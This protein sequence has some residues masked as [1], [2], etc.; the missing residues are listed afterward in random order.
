MKTKLTLLLI[1]NFCLVI[2]S[3]S[4]RLTITQAGDTILYL[5]TI[6]TTENGDTT[7]SSPCLG[8]E[9]ND[10]N[11]IFNYQDENCLKQGLWIEFNKK[12]KSWHTGY[13]KNSR[14]KG[15]WKVYSDEGL[16]N[17]IEI[18][19][20]QKGQ[21]LNTNN[22]KTKRT[23]V[24]VFITRNKELIGLLI[25]LAYFIRQLINASIINAIE[26][27]KRNLLFLNPFK[28]S[29]YMFVLKSILTI[30][31]KESI[32]KHSSHKT[33]MLF[34]NYLGGLFVLVI[35]IMTALI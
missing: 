35:I 30:W 23:K 18:Q 29:N 11:E 2:K 4:Q 17:L 21:L 32:K 14:K 8:F 6:E 3:T 13:Y 5:K 28:T 22:D 26:N 15:E 12:S 27:K 10:D 1:L 16:N 25:A 9:I 19:E 31:T 7:F 33:M 34:S 24:N 20:F